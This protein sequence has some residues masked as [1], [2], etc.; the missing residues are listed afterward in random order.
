MFPL[1]FHIRYFNKILRHVSLSNILS[2]FFSKSGIARQK[3]KNLVS[4][5][6][7][8]S[9]KT[10]AIPFAL[11]HKMKSLI[12]TMSSPTL[13]IILFNILLVVIYR[14]SLGNCA[15]N[16]NHVIS[17]IQPLPHLQ[18]SVLLAIPR[19]RHILHPEQHKKTASHHF[20]MFF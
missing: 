4:T 10:L 11:T 3:F 13:D 17:A 18:A 9:R 19:I 1:V 8:F 20:S 5:A 15:S 6:T 2:I 16:L 7:S 12:F 14:T